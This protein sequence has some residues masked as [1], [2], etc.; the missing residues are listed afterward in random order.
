MAAR[1]KIERSTL[2]KDGDLHVLHIPRLLKVND[3]C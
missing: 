2:V 3:Q 1:A